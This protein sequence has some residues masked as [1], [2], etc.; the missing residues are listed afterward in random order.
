MKLRAWMD[1]KKISMNKLAPQ[2]D[3]DVSTISRI[4]RGETQPSWPLMN[5]LLI[6]T[7]GQ[8]KPNDFL[9]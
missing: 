7:A 3:C 5:K 2:C 6:V 8:V 1:K 9:K 4:S